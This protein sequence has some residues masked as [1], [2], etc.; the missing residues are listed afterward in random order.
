MR[1]QWHTEALIKEYCQYKHTH[2]VVTFCIYGVFSINTICLVDTVRLI[3]LQFID[4]IIKRL[5]NNMCD[6]WQARQLYII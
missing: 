4:L 5:I 1:T 6:H 2:N 3:Y